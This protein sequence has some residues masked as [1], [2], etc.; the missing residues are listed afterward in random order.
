MDLLRKE[1]EVLA[2]NAPLGRLLA[3]YQVPEEDGMGAV[4]C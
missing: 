4:N 3:D 2:C 1:R